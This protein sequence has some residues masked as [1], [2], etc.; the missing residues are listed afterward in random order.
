VPS[1]SPALEGAS[2]QRGDNGTDGCLP[3]R[4]C[5]LELCYLSAGPQLR[6]NI[7]L[8][9][10]RGKWRGGWK[11]SWPRSHAHPRV[12]RRPL[13]SCLRKGSARSI[14]VIFLLCH[15]VHLFVTAHGG[16]KLSCQLLVA[17]KLLGEVG[18]PAYRAVPPAAHAPTN[19]AAPGLTLSWSCSTAGLR[20]PLIS[21]EH[22]WQTTADLCNSKCVS[23]LG[24][25][26]YPAAHRS[27]PVCPGQRAV[28]PVDSHSSK[29]TPQPWS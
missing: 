14:G 19:Y 18:E 4:T 6:D 29:D 1:E 27:L 24:Q 25:L 10:F 26:M 5:G 7:A 17:V 9:T 16:L 21:Q 2:V 28:T 13:W 15:L 11:L 22:A 23:A 12:Q 8:G 3:Y 20:F